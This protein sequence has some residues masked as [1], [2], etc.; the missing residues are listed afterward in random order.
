MT[1]NHHKSKLH[2]SD[3]Y[4]CM[5]ERFVKRRQHLVG[6]NSSTLKVCI[7]V[8]DLMSCFSLILLST[9][10]KKCVLPWSGA[11]W[12]LILTWCL[13]HDMLYH[14]CFLDSSFWCISDSNIAMQALE[15]LTG[16][17]ILV[18]VHC[19]HYSSIESY[20]LTW[21]FSVFICSILAL[22]HFSFKW[23]GEHCCCYGFI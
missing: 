3:L 10:R 12:P 18:Q 7:M 13:E 14:V 15:I 1:W 9:T 22:F 20:N 21:I 2:Q 17:Y 4:P 8:W 11:L 16:C 5:Q 6:P 23:A 19:F